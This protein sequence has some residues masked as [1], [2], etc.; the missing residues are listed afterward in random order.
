MRKIKAII[1]GVTILF[2]AAPPIA[3]ASDCTSPG[4]CYGTFLTALLALLA[5]VAIIA[6]AVFVVPILLD[7]GAVAIG[8]GLDLL[9]DMLFGDMIGSALAEGFAEG[10]IEFEAEEVTALELGQAYEGAFTEAISAAD[11]ASGAFEGLSPSE[12]M[13]G[14]SKDQ[15]QLLRQFMGGGPQGA[16]DSLA[17]SEIPEGLSSETL[18]AYREI[19]RRAI[20]EGIDTQGAQRL[21]MVLVQ[22][23]IELLG[24]S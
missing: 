20:Q 6:A 16:I 3:Y 9:G 8:F 1:A 11:E 7:L 4:D 19:A 12:V 13:D 2:L 22:R 24:G 21:R 17:N 23:G 14:V 18:Q 10:A 5:I 15:M